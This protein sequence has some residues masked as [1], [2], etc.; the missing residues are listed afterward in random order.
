VHVVPGW[1]WE[2][3]NDT[4]PQRLAQLREF[5]A[6]HGEFPACGVPPVL[7]DG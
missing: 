3:G 6:K 7:R 1:K 2:G 4:F 5:V